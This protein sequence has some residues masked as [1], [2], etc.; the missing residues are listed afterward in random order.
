MRILIGLSI[1][2]ELPTA[3]SS[4]SKF[5]KRKEFEC[6]NYILRI[7]IS[8][9][10]AFI[11][12]NFGGPLKPEYDLFQFTIRNRDCG[13]LEIEFPPFPGLYLRQMI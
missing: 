6:D 9:N 12:D 5:D 4:Y 11:I 10:D 7:Q 2:K 1:C 8:H 3:L 13:Y